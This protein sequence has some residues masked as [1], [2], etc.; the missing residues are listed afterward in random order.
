M[1]FLGLRSLLAP[2]QAVTLRA[3]SP[4]RL[5]LSCLTETCGKTD[6]KIHAYWPMRSHFHSSADKGA[7]RHSRLCRSALTPSTA[8]KAAAI[9]IKAELPK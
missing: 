1:C 3:F 2:A 6:W 4:C 8:S 9:S 7:A 5:F